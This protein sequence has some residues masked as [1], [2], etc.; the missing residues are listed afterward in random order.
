MQLFPDLVDDDIVV[1]YWHQQYNIRG[2]HQVAVL[3]CVAGV[4]VSPFDI[5]L[6]PIAREV[7]L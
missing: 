1:I 2:E 6:D 7:Q 3:F 4:L 5:D